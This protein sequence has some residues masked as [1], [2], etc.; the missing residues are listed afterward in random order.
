METW[1]LI[2]VVAID[3]IEMKKKKTKKTKSISNEHCK[4]QLHH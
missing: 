2:L 1:S 4:K 3:T